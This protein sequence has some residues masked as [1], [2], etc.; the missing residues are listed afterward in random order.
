MSLSFKRPSHRARFTSTW[1]F[2][3]L[4]ALWGG[5]ALAQEPAAGLPLWEIGAF[6]GSLSAPAYPASVERFTR[7]LVLPYVIYRG[8]VLRADREGVGA[9]W[10]LA[11][12]YQFDFG[13]SGSFAASSADV[14]VRQN[15]PDLGTLV[16]VGPRLRITLARPGPGMRV[17]LDLPLRGV[18]E[19]HGGLQSRGL[20]FE[21]SLVLEASD[22]GAGWSLAAKGGLVWGDQQLN[23]YFYGVP[24]AYATQLRPYFEAQSGLI[25]ARISLSASHNI[26]PDVRFFGYA[27]LDQYGL[28]SNTNSPLSLQTSSPTVGVGL[29]WTLGRSDTRLGN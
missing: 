26:S 2:S 7:I 15:M 25:S 13:A 12:G 1:V 17:G 9:R 20:V 16:E 28:G 23:Q 6:A 8:D 29:T 14:A 18:V 22:I 24:L 11:P 5:S 21:P 27:R 19:I 4:C 3:A 10:Q